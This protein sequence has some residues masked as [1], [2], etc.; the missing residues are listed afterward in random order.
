MHGEIGRRRAEPGE[1]ECRYEELAAWVEH[2][3]NL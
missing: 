3:S 2:P 1:P